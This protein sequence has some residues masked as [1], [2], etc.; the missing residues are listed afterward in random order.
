LGVYPGCVLVVGD[1]NGILFEMHA[2]HTCTGPQKMEVAEHTIFDVASLTKPLATA[3]GIMKLVSDQIIHL[4]QS[5]ADFLP[6]VIPEDK[7]NITIRQLLSHCSG[8]PDWKPYYKLVQGKESKEAKRAMRNLVLDTSLEYEPGEK[9]VY[10]DLG[11]ILLEWVVEA[12]TGVRLPEFV[13]TNFYDPLGLIRTFFQEVDKPMAFGP[14]EYAAT[15]VCPWRGRMIRGYVHDEN[16]FAMGGYSGHAGLF[17]TAREAY[18]LCACLLQHYYG[19][20]SDLLGH[21]VVA[22]FFG[23]Q[24]KPRGST[25]ALGWDTP[26]DTGSSSGKYFSKSSVGHLGFTGTSIWMD[27]DR[28]LI[29][30]F[31]TNRIHPSRKNVKIKDLRPSLHDAVVAWFDARNV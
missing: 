7:T 12:V 14:E 27:L 25:W 28:D 22:H 3:L 20:R 15:E 19:S 1:S 2:G 10:S 26:S 30:V 17:S 21:W 24:D 18:R 6:P 8:L 13:K 29:V 11:Y 9:A 31:F 5:L 4:D 16:A 23:R